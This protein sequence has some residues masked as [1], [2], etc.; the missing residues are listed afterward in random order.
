MPPLPSDSPPPEGA[1]SPSCYHL[2]LLFW[3]PFFS[4]LYFLCLTILL[5]ILARG[6][7]GH[8]CH[9]IVIWFTEGEDDADSREFVKHQS[10]PRSLAQ[11]PSSRHHWHRGNRHTSIKPRD[12]VPKDDRGFDTAHGQWHRGNHPTSIQPTAT[13]CTQPNQSHRQW[14]N[15]PTSI[16]PQTL[17]PNGSGLHTSSRRSCLLDNPFSMT[18]SRHC[19]LDD[20]NDL[21]LTISSHTPFPTVPSRQS[22]LACHLISTTAPHQQHPATDRCGHISRPWRLRGRSLHRKHPTQMMGGAL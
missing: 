22:Y 21:I 18:S 3:R 6:Q 17:D 12:R 20:L 4:P 2:T 9:K 7:H 13:A 14:G 16:P 5:K 8:T 19:L 1:L 10:G 11:T 15:H